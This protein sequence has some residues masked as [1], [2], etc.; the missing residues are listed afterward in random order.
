MAIEETL[1][2]MIEIQKRVP[3]AYLG[4]GGFDPFIIAFQTP[5]TEAAITSFEKKTGCKIPEDYKKFLLFTNGVIFYGAGD[6]RLFDIDEVLEVTMM[7]EYKKGIYIIG[8]FLEDYIV[9]NSDEI[10][11]G[12]YL[13][14]GPAIFA[15]DFKPFEHNFEVFLDRLLMS[16]IQ[17]YWDWFP[18][19][20]ELYDFSK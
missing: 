1:Q 12:K 3:L 15:T 16:Q 11:T 17:K 7:M 18:R 20:Q 13:Y 2:A 19:N 8:Y 6:F 5:A 14:F 9:V 10:S 4:E